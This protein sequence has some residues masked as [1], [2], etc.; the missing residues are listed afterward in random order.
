MHTY[1]PHT[2]VSPGNPELHT[3]LPRFVEV[4]SSALIYADN[5][6][7]IRYLNPAATAMMFLTP[8][9]RPSVSGLLLRRTTAAE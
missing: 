3:V 2:S 5:T 7:T 8:G 1:S 9:R 4:T 6:M